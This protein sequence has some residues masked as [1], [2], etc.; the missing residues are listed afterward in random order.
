MMKAIC[1][2]VATEGRFYFFWTLYGDN[3]KRTL[4]IFLWFQFSYTFDG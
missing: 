4:K 2:E 3:C 1:E